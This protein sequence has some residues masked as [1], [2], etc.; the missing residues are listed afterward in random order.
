MS[1]SIHFFARFQWKDETSPVVREWLAAVAAA[2]VPQDGSAPVIPFEVPEIAE[3]M[4][5]DVPW[6]LAGPAHVQVDRWGATVAAANIHDDAQMTLYGLVFLLAPQCVDGTAAVSWTDMWPDDEPSVF[7]VQDGVAFIG[8]PNGTPIAAT[9]E[10]EPPPWRVAGTEVTAD[11]LAWLGVPGGE[12]LAA[13]P[14]PAISRHLLARSIASG[15]DEYAAGDAE[16]RAAAEAGARLVLGLIEEGGDPS[17]VKD[18]PGWQL[19]EV[20]RR[21]RTGGGRSIPSTGREVTDLVA[22][23]D[24]IGAH[25]PV[26]VPGRLRVGEVIELLEP[27]VVHAFGPDVTL[28]WNG[29]PSTTAHTF[30]AEVPAGTQ[31]I[32]TVVYDLGHAQCGPVEGDDAFA[33]PRLPPSNPFGMSPDPVAPADQYTFG[34]IDP[35]DEGTRFRRVT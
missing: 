11:E 25:R 33:W 19:Q 17:V 21:D 27:I 20:R 35:K 10:E 13:D 26:G 6:L 4:L 8:G 34:P 30:D 15:L 9:A 24:E 3:G 5:D 7:W 28:E 22:A 12:A 1:Y 32:L 31:L 18:T 2:P 16:R 23:L 29:M 14:G